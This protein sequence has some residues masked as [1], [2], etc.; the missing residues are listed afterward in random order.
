MK[1]LARQHVLEFPRRPLIMG[2][3]NLGADSFSGDGITDLDRAVERAKQMLQEGADIVDVGAE[4][5]RTNR[6]AMSEREEADTLGAF[7]E[8]W[9]EICATAPAGS[10]PLLSINTWRPAVCREVLASGG[11]LLNDIGAL[12]TPENA[13]ICAATGTALLIMHSIGEPKVPHTHVG[14]DDVMAR[15]EEFFE[16][17]LAVAE[18]AGL[19]RA[20]TILDPGIDFAK[21]RADNLRI[22][23]ELDRLQ[24]FGRPI[25]L[26]I[27]RK[28]VIGQVLDLPVPAERDAGTVACLVSGLLRGAG[29]FRVHNV[30]AAAQAARIIAAVQAAE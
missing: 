29:I 20:A 27:S 4:S 26:P 9:P 19:S 24:R 1:L 5:A 28:T 10:Q 3:L 25:L 7:T 11:D 21:Q 2:I 22:Y 14:Y 18:K 12:P 23:R 6:A 13:E 16:E 17:K 8:R 15:M 30:R